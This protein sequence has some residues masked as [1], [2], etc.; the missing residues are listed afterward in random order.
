MSKAEGK[1]PARFVKTPP[2]VEDHY[3]SRP[4]L[5][6]QE[7]LM[8]RS[9]SPVLSQGENERGASDRFGRGRPQMHPSR[10]AAMALPRTGYDDT[11]DDEE[12][13][14]MENV[15]RAVTESLRTYNQERG[16][17]GAGGSASRDLRPTQQQQQQQHFGESSVSSLHGDG[18]RDLVL[19]ETG[20]DIGYDDMDVDME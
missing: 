11:Y 10:A 4:P 16:L 19:K 15:E 7:K 5:R 8:D 9:M 6:G 1:K 14:D 18:Y 17:I 2:A 3:R 13:A 20:F 12:M